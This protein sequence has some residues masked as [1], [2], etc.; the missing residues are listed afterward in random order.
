VSEK[1]V[2]HVS[3][4]LD[5]I[6]DPKEVNWDRG[7]LGVCTTDCDPDIDSPALTNRFSP[8][9]S[10]FLAD[11]W[12]EKEAIGDVPELNEVQVLILSFSQYGRYRALLKRLTGVER[13]WM[14]SSL[15]AALGGFTVKTKRT[16]VLFCR[17]HF[18]YPE[19]EEH[20][21]LCNHLGMT[22]AQCDCV[23]NGDEFSSFSAKAKRTSSQEEEIKARRVSGVGVGQLGV[24]SL[25]VR[26]PLGAVQSGTSLYIKMLALDRSSN[27]FCRRT[28]P[29]KTALRKIS[30]PS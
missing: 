8:A 5:W 29:A 24:L 30:S 7:L 27:L 6:A 20:P 10:D 28:T 12:Q 9:H 13:R 3:D 25:D 18:D 22:T 11:V 14:H 15:V 2:L 26:V 1:A 16:H 4:L 19:L 23:R 17:D 21:F